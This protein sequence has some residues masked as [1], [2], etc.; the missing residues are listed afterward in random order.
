MPHI[1][2]IRFG[3]ESWDLSG[4]FQLNLSC[5][6]SFPLFIFASECIKAS[7]TF[8]FLNGWA[9]GCHYVLRLCRQSRATEALK[10]SVSAFIKQALSYARASFMSA[11]SSMLTWKIIGVVLHKRLCTAENTAAVKA[12]IKKHGKLITVLDV[13]LSRT[14]IYEILH[15][16]SAKKCARWMPRP[17]SVHHICRRQW[18]GKV[19]FPARSGISREH[20]QYGWVLDGLLLS[21]TSCQLKPRPK[22]VQRSCFVWW[23]SIVRPPFTSFS[24]P[25][26]NQHLKISH[27]GPDNLPVPSEQEKAGKVC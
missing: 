23:L 14:S 21:R 12:L 9:V 4:Q 5:N 26:A 3:D 10:H 20:Y 18:T 25:T 13:I 1:K 11:W 16:D 27:R 24:C 22:E 17:W 2:N 15:E 6:Q 7:T 19:S 8:L